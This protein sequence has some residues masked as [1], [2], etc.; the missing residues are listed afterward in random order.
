MLSVLPCLFCFRLPIALRSFT[1][2]FI[3]TIFYLVVSYLTPVALFGHLAVFRIEL[4]LAAVVFLVSLPALSKSFILKSPQSLALIGLALAVFMSVLI[5]V[6]WPG[7]A[8][9]AFLGFL[10]S[11]FAYFLVCLHCDSKKKLQVLVLMLLFVC[12]FV[13]AHGCNED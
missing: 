8:V 7:G 6:R 1:M 10:P 5:A 2:G 9:Y 13:I 12:L 3:L 4:I 11:A